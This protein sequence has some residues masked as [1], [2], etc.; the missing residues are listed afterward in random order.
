MYAYESFADEEA[1][2]CCLETLPWLYFVSV[3]YVRSRDQMPQT[4]ALAAMFF[5]LKKLD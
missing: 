1:R 2:E 4:A 3:N 5:A